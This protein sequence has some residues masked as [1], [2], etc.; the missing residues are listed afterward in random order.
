MIFKVRVERDAQ[1]YLFESRRDANNFIESLHSKGGVGNVQIFA[2]EHDKWIKQY[3][4]TEHI[5]NR[6]DI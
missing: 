1:E 4:Y 3:T 6:E 2:A 5:M